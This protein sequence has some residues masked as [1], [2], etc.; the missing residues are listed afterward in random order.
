MADRA[1]VKIGRNCKITLG[2]TKIL[3][4]G[5]WQMSG[6]NTD[7]LDKTEFG[8]TWKQY[9]LGLLDGGE[10][11]F[12]GLYDPT[13]SEGQ[14]ALRT[15]NEAGTELT[16]LRFWVDNTSYWAPATT[17]PTSHLLIS[18]WQVSVDKAGLAQSSFTAK[19]AGKMQ[20]V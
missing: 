7:L 3:G 14:T 20:L 10:I 16:D 8:D 1:T 13:D 9:V 18:Q 6:V 19:I 17:N 2:S 4:M 5:T 11:T 12:N 15:A